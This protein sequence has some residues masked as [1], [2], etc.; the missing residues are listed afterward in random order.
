[1]DLAT[2]LSLVSA[3]YVNTSS[4]GTRQRAK[5]EALLQEKL[6]IPDIITK[7]LATEKSEG[8]YDLIDNY[9]ISDKNF[10]TFVEPSLEGARLDQI[11]GSIHRVCGQLN[12]DGRR[13]ATAAELLLFGLK[14][15][16]EQGKYWIFA[17]GQ[18]FEYYDD[19]GEC[20]KCMVMLRTF[21]GDRQACLVRYKDVLCDY[22]SDSYRIL[23]FPL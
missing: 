17:P 8:G 13:A 12:R 3:L 15:P 22:E 4:I 18:I 20:T 7:L 1:M 21:R 19:R 23:S 6:P 5:L 2:A 10:P 11:P 14:N 16:K 9:G